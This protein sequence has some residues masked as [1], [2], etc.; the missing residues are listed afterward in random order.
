MWRFMFGLAIALLVTALHSATAQDR[1]VVMIDAGHGGRDAGVQYQG[2]NEKDYALRA[3]FAFAEE[4]AIRGYD[5]VL[6][7]TGDTAIGYDDR[8]AIAEAANAA[9]FISLHINGSEEDP[10]QHGTVI[11]ANVEDP[12]VA[13]IASAVE[14]ALEEAGGSV[15]VEGR[16]WD[17]LKSP[18]ASTIM[19]EMG[20]MT[21]PVE[22]R[23]V[24][25]SSYHHQMAATIADAVAGY[26]AR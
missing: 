12:K 5:V 7:R 18:T 13:A 3:S 23:L 20:Y 16:P 24:L 1:V 25:S 17:F 15:E 19:I 14:T 9:L 2:I 10:S 11:F 21:H 8:R 6:T 4:F 26:L 22:R